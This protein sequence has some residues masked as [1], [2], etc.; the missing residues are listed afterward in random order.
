MFHFLLIFFPSVSF[1]LTSR[2]FPFYLYFPLFH[3]LPLPFLFSFSFL[4]PTILPMFSFCLSISFFLFPLILVLFILRP[5]CSHFIAFPLFSLFYFLSLIYFNV[6]PFDIFPLLFLFSFPM[7]PPFTIHVILSFSHFFLLFV[8]LPSF[9]FG[10]V[11]F[12]CCGLC[13]DGCFGCE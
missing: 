10:L 12:V 6:L 7:F 8:S 1:P 2:L 13:G 3:F 9:P 5:S 4:P 11:P